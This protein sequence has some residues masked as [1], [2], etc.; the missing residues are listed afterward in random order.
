ML[1]S[2]GGGGVDLMSYQGSGQSQHDSEIGSNAALT[3]LDKGESS[4]FSCSIFLV[5]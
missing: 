2:V 3:E 5:L 4:F 1:S